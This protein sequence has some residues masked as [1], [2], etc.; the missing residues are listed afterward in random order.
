MDAGDGS[1]LRRRRG[2]AREVPPAIAEALFS[3][4]YSLFEERFLLQ[5]ELPSILRDFPARVAH[6]A[7][8][9]TSFIQHGIRVVDMQIDFTWPAQMRQPD[10]STFGAGD[11]HMAHL[12]GSLCVFIS[13]DA[14][15]FVVAPEGAVEQQHV[16]VVELL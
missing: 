6:L 11:R 15:Q 12:A 16:G 2:V 7:I 5:I 9:G 14:D 10:Q 13:L 3:S 4:L 8:F 1:V